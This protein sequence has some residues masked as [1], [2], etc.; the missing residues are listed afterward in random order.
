VTISTSNVSYFIVLQRYVA[1]L[2]LDGKKVKSV[3]AI[4]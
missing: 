1:L 3:T 2:L 4:Y